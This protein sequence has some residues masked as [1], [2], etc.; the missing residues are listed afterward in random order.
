M[1]NRT[2]VTVDATSIPTAITLAA[3]AS[4]CAWCRKTGQLRRAIEQL[5]TWIEGTAGPK[6]GCNTCLSIVERGLAAHLPDTPAATATATQC[7]PWCTVEHNEID[8]EHAS[9]VRELVDSTGGEVFAQLLQQPGEP[10]TVA[11]GV[12]S[13][14]GEHVVHVALEDGLKAVYGLLNVIHSARDAGSR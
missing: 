6:W 14:R 1:T 7:P 11:I 4:V 12:S 5:R 8:V 2:G 3:V 10:A 9:E 13:D